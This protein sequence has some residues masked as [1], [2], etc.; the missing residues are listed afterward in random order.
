MASQSLD[1]D[2]RAHSYDVRVP[3]HV[4]PCVQLS[5]ASTYHIATNHSLT[6]AIDYSQSP[7]PVADTE[8]KMGISRFTEKIHQIAHRSPTKLAGRTDLESHLNV[9][10]D[11]TYPRATR[12]QDGS[13]LGV[14]TAFQGGANIISAT[15]SLD[16]GVTWTPV[17]E[18]TRGIGDI[19]N[20]FPVQLPS[21]KILCAFRNHTKDENGHYTWYRITICSSIDNGASWQFLSTADEVSLWECSYFLLD[22]L[23][24]FWKNGTTGLWEPFMRIARDGSLQLYYS[25][26]LARNDQDSIQRISY[27][28]GSSWGSE[29]TISGAGL[30]ARDGMLGLAPYDDKLIAVFETNEH[31]PMAIKAVESPGKIL[32]FPSCSVYSN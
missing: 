1:P 15:R 31:G 3:Q 18:I 16:H 4:S 23:L 29:R 7:D 10:G 30:E 17:S 8:D 22:E 32:H 6:I 14:H 25:L 9:I 13:I 5:L 26:E 12:L 24:T 2:S 21:G 20:A 28:E 19:D 11:G 27:D